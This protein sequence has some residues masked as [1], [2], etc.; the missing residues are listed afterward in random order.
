[1]MKVHRLVIGC[2]VVGSLGLGI[3]VAGACTNSGGGGRHHT[4][5]TP[6]TTT[7]TVPVVTAAG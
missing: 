6:S 3:G 2:V 5:W 4:E 7:S 1:M